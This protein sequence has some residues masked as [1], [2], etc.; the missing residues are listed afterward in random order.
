MSLIDITPVHLCR[1]GMRCPTLWVDDDQYVFIGKLIARPSTAVKAKVGKGE[2]AVRI[3]RD[4]FDAAK[5]PARSSP[6]ATHHDT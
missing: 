2:V 5:P 3:P 1:N 4:L 6:H